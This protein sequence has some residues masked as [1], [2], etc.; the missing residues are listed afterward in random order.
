MGSGKIVK[1]ISNFFWILGVVTDLQVDFLGEHHLSPT[2]GDLILIEQAKG[3]NLRH[4]TVL[5]SHKLKS[6][7]VIT[8]KLRQKSKIY[9]RKNDFLNFENMFLEHFCKAF[10]L[11]Q[12][13][14]WY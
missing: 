14:P 12:T 7:Y 11:Q 5:R 13:F 6:Y 2:F 10:N 1:K 8:K 9:D 4:M 3:F